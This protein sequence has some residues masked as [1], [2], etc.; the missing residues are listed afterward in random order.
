MGLGPGLGGRDPRPAVVTGTRL[1]GAPGRRGSRD[2][3]RRGRARDPRAVTSTHALDE[4]LGLS[5]ADARSVLGGKATNLGV[6]A[7]DLGLPVPPGFVITTETCR[8]YLADG[9]PPGLD[10]E[11]RERMA[12][13]S[14]PSPDAGSAT[15]ADPPPRQRALRSA[16]LDARDDG[17]DPRPRSRRRD[18]GR[19]RPGHRRRCLRPC[20]PRTVRGE[21]PFDRRRPEVSGRPVGAASTCD[22]GGLPLV[23]E[24]ACPDV[25]AEGGHRRRPRDRRHRPGDGVRQSRTDVRDRGA[26]HARPGDGRAGPLRRRAVRRAGRGRRRRD[27][28][29]RA[30]RRPRCA[31]PRGRRRT[32]ACRRDPR[33]PLP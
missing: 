33:A 17:H 25:P 15:R 7:R 22:R 23:G 16:R 29:D 19:P 32:A 1:A 26:V 21:L 13:A 3:D 5:D 20:L 2:D 18:E 30:H 8:R 4:P 31:T 10:D 11:L 12:R 9:W 6:M 24:R 28:C 14:R 27:A